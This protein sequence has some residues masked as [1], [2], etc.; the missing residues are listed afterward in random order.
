MILGDVRV[1]IMTTGEYSVSACM[2]NM[3]LVIVCD[4]TLLPS[5]LCFIVRLANDCAVADVHDAISP[6]LGTIA[7]DNSSGPHVTDQLAIRKVRDDEGDA[8]YA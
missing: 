2:P 6:T 5:V 4:V 7:Q 8:R 3:L 1:L